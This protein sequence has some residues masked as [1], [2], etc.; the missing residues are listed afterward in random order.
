M[1]P[2]DQRLG[3][4]HRA[5]LEAH[6]RLVE[7]PQLAAL[8]PVLELLLDAEGLTARSRIALS[9]SSVRAPPRS[10]ARYIAASASSTSRVAV[11]LL[12][13]LGERDADRGGEP[14]LGSAGAQRLRDLA[15]EPVRHADR[16]QHAAHRL[17]E[18]R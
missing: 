7:E 2:A 10:L 12:P 4:D 11:D 6:E 8:E 17:A 5:R 13:G 9:N 14:Q 16:L 1:L 15:L 18:D 3:A